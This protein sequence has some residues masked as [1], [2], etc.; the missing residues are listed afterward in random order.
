[1]KNVN[2]F[3]IAKVRASGCFLAFAWFFANFSLT[4]LIKVLL[5]KKSVYLSAFFSVALLSFFFKICIHLSR[6]NECIGSSSVVFPHA[7]VLL[8]YLNLILICRLFICCFFC[9]KIKF[10][11]KVDS[12]VVK[13]WFTLFRKSLCSQSFIGKNKI[14]DGF[15]KKI[16]HSPNTPPTPGYILAS[17]I[18][19]KT[20]NEWKLT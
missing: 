2:N 12:S 4:L 15:P 10:G 9:W 7:V 3:Q 8:P 5:I 20:H 14:L 19:Q 6:K 1:M 13:T 17:E 18:P 11:S 16:L